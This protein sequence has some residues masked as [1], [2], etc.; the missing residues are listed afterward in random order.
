MFRAMANA[1]GSRRS[2]R[3]WRRC[4]HVSPTVVR[5]A[6]SPTV[7]LLLLY[8]HYYYYCCCCYYYCYYYYY[9]RR[10]SSLVVAS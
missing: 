9:Y 4:E 5:A 2:C 10:R 3:S 6:L 1:G 7:A 8:Y